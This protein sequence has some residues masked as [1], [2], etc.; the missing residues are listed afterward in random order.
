MPLTSFRTV[1]SAGLTVGAFTWG[2]LVDI[3][4][5]RWAFNLTVGIVAVFG[6][7]SPTLSFLFRLLTRAPRQA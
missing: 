3:I 7:L 1:F 4:G 2:I 6:A 5:R